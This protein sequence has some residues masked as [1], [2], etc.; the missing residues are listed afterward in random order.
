MTRSLPNPSNLLLEVSKLSCHIGDKVILDAVSFSMKPGEMRAIIG[1]NG[2]GKSTCV[3]CLC[4]II[5][6]WKGS[7]KLA[8]RSISRIDRRELAGLVCYLPQSRGIPPAFTVWDFVSMGRYVHTGLLAGLKPEDVE[9]IHDALAVTGM[10]HLRHRML[11]TLSGGELQMAAIAAGLA[12]GAQLLVLDE[13]ATFLDPVRQEMLLQ[14][15]QRLNH[16][17][18]VGVLMITHD[19]NAAICFTEYTLALRD[20]RVVY[21]GLSCDLASQE[22]LRKIYEMSFRIA[23]LPGKVQLAIPESLATPHGKKA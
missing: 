20:G 1:S 3:R 11:P 4:K 18:G 8:G 7:V 13:P 2:S 9:H 15:L 14:L 6:N 17:R 5:D 12:Q 22:T 10:E 19:V 21:D 23:D 16:E